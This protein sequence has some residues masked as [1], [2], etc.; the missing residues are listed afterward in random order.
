MGRSQGEKQSPGIGGREQH[1]GGKE[2]QVHTERTTMGQA[3]GKS[4]KAVAGGQ[5]FNV[6]RNNVFKP[7]T[8]DKLANVFNGLKCFLHKCR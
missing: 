6:N 8:V 1:R 4:E 5:K 3:G 2:I 7:K